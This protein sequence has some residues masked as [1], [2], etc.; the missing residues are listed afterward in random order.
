MFIQQNG[1]RLLILSLILVLMFSLAAC[2]GLSDWIYENLPENYV[3]VHINS[4]DIILCR[5]SGESYDTVINRYI[6]S[7][8][9]N[10][11]YIGLKRIPVDSLQ[12]YGD[13]DIKEADPTL[14]EYYLIDT[15]ETLVYGPYSYEEYEQKIQSV[16]INQMGE[17]ITTSNNPN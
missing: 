15:Q 14:V 1:S 16:G 12:P 7:F 2:P 8:C 17:W 9:K 5:K 4:N 6:E 10:E 11:R 13:F 3:I